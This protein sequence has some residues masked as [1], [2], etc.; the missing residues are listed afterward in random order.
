MKTGKLIIEVD[1]QRYILFD[2]SSRHQTERL[3]SL[4]HVRHTAQIR[5]RPR[6]TAGPCPAVPTQEAIPEKGGH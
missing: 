3:K 2:K 5:T 6:A 4:N 1:V